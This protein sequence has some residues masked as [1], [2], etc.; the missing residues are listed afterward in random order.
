MRQRLKENVFTKLFIIRE[1]NKYL[2][3][4]LVFIFTGQ[5]ISAQ[6]A[7]IAIGERIG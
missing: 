5:R 4:L 6:F 2:N 7:L 1:G 3:A